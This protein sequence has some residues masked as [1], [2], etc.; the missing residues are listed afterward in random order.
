MNLRFVCQWAVRRL[1]LWAV[2]CSRGSVCFPF[3]VKPPL[4]RLDYQR[5]YVSVQPSDILLSGISILLLEKPSSLIA[6]DGYITMSVFD[7][8]LLNKTHTYGKRRLGVLE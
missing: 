2:V 7:S 5:N 1:A 8:L 3:P 6:E 4:N